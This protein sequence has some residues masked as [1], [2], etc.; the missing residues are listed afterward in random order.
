MCLSKVYL[1]SEHEEKEIMKDVARMEAE[2]RGFWLIN[3]FG[4]RRYVEGVIET[5]DFDNGHYVR[6]RKEEAVP[7]LSL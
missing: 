3:L 4:E 7:T 6:L 5:I 2:G 1:G